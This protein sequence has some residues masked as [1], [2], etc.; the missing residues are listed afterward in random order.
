MRM[1]VSRGLGG[2]IVPVRLLD[3]PKTVTAGLGAPAAISK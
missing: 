1:A 3:R 2:S